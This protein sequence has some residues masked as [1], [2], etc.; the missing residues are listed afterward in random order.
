M[1]PEPQ[2]KLTARQEEFLRRFYELCEEYKADDIQG[3]SLGVAIA[4]RDG[5][6]VQ[7]VKAEILLLPAE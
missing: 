3:Y 7:A 1:Q 6:W 2:P 4:S 5:K